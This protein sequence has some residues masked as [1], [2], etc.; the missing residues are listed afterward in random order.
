VLAYISVICD[1]DCRSIEP[2]R[3]CDFAF[4]NV[5][6]E[7]EREFVERGSTCTM[8]SQVWTIALTREVLPIPEPPQQ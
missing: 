4:L 6:S 8:S 3:D 1:V 5:V 2:L 7:T